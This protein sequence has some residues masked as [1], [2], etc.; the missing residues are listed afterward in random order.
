MDIP[1]LGL[2]GM[3][4][5]ITGAGRGMGT[6]IAAALAQAGAGVAINRLLPDRMTTQAP[7]SDAR[8]PRDHRPP[9]SPSDR[10]AQRT[11][12]TRTSSRD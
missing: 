10:G 7:R 5:P 8:S 6:G 12:L 3:V 2:H 9:P 1:E 4:A 11:W